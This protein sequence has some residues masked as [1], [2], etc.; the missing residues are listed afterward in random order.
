MNV[1]KLYVPWLDLSYLHY[2]VT[3]T[4]LLVSPP[5]PRNAIYRRSPAKTSSAQTTPL[6]RALGFPHNLKQSCDTPSTQSISTSKMRRLKPPKETCLI[7]LGL[8][9]VEP[10]AVCCNK[11]PMQSSSLFAPNC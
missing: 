11:H 6:P 2:P 4:Y 3:D 10:N 9:P 7:Y 5:R 1:L 8:P